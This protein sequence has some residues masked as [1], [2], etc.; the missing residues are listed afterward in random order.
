[1]PITTFTTASNLAVRAVIALCEQFVDDL[2]YVPY[3]RSALDSVLA[4]HEAHR[5]DDILPLERDDIIAELV[6]ALPWLNTD[7]LA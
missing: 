7:D 1:M 4:Y 6:E 3:V 5:T 2:P